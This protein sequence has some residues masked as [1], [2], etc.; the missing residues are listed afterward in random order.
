MFGL[1]KI[2]LWI[3][4]LIIVVVALLAL[5]AWGGWQMYG[6]RIQRSEAAA[7]R[8]TDSQESAKLETQ[9][10]QETTRQVETFNHLTID[11]RSQTDEARNAINSAPQAN[12]PLDPMSSCVGLGFGAS[13]PT[14][15]QLQTT[16]DP[17]QVQVP[18]TAK[19]ACDL[20]QLPLNREPIQADVNYGYVTRGAQLVVCDAKRQMAVSAS[21]RE[22]QLELEWRQERARRECPWYRKLTFSCQIPK[23]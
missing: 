14:Q 22:H 4:G 15:A 18:Q 17:P 20:Y 13:R 11:V 23:E 12:T 21:E 8:A 5:V 3:I 9:G 1:S 16:A 6:G 10:A 2:T 19:E 7:A